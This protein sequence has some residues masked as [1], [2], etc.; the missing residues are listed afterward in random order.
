MF[1]R[2]DFFSSFSG[3]YQ[4][5]YDAIVGNVLNLLP[6]FPKGKVRLRSVFSELCKIW[7]VG[8]DTAFC[9]KILRS[10]YWKSAAGRDRGMN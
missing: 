9:K 2:W 3:I 1:G 8:T 7:G 5:I 4:T 6:R 10:L